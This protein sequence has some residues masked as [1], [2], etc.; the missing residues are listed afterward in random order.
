MLINYIVIATIIVIFITLG[1]AFVGMLKGDKKGS[2][3]FFKSLKLRIILSILLFIFL[4]FAGI[5]G[6]VEPNGAI[7]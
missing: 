1:S 6:W 5:L 3:K 7:F 2:D 4:I